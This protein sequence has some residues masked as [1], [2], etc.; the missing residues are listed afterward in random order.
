MPI[1]E[2]MNFVPAAAFPVAY[3]TVHLALT[4]RARLM[5]GQTLLVHGASGSV[6]RAALE[7]GKGSGATR[8][9]TGGSE[10][11]LEV[12]A[13]R[14]AEYLIDYGSEDIRDRVLE[15]TAG[16]GA[17]VV[18]DTVGGDPSTPLCAV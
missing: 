7:I 13:K 5:E 12:A 18:F 3:G 1:P 14:G 16:R 15:I 8:I 6:G 11:S 17:D 4:R 9:A 10:E 2:G